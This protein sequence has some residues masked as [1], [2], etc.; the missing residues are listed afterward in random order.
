MK[1]LI[2]TLAMILSFSSGA[3]NWMDISFGQLPLT[4]DFALAGEVSKGLI[5]KERVQIELVMEKEHIGSDVNDSYYANKS[6][7]RVH[8]KLDD[9]P[10]CEGI[11]YLAAEDEIRN[12]NFAMDVVYDRDG[13]V[14]GFNCSNK[15]EGIELYA[16]T[17]IMTGSPVVGS[18]VLY[19]KGHQREYSRSQTVGYWNMGKVL[20]LALSDQDYEEMEVLLEAKRSF[21]S[22]SRF[23][24]KLALREG[25]FKVSC[26]VE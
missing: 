2:L 18:V 7:H 11:S 8:F 12:V 16:T 17:A 6:Y 1:Y 15:E 10:E 20:K 23:R 21:Y 26:I 13:R 4:K 5:F 3:T 19:Y 22:H 14:E 24:G 9:G 25:T